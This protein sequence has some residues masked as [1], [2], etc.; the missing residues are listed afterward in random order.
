VLQFSLTAYD[1]T[2]LPGGSIDPLGFERGYLFLADKILPGL[3]NVA[4]RPRY[5]SM[6]CAGAWLADISEHSPV[7]VQYRGRVEAVL[8]FERLWALANVLASDEVGVEALTTSGIRGVTYADRRAKSIY[9]KHASRTDSDFKLL[10]R[11]LTYGAIGIYGYVAQGMQLLDRQTLALTPALGARLAQAF[12]DETILPPQLKRAVRE[13]DNTRVSIGALRD[14]GARAHVSSP[15]GSTESSCL[16]EA[17]YRDPTRSRMLAILEEF[18]ASPGELELDRL[19][20]I[21]EGL[22]G[23]IGSVDLHEAIEAILAYEGV[24]RWLL[25]AFERLLYLGREYTGVTGEHIKEDVV[26]QSVC[27]E[28]PEAIARC[29]SVLN[30]DH[31]APEFRSGLKRVEDVSLFLAVCLEASDSPMML[32]DAILGRH[33]DVQHGKKD[34]GRRKQ[35]WIERQGNEITLTL[36][37]AGRLDEPVDPM[38]VIPHPYRLSS[39]DALIDAAV[40]P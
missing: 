40:V 11:Q 36:T 15:V 6:L 2:D 1:P 23:D 35:P 17:A 32:A 20:R 18:P 33:A 24:Y 16:R 14:W 29:Q 37:A 8:R 22:Q 31:K 28:L 7:R 34:G 21:S 5:F 26:L 4:N 25:L 27:D 9:R 38:Q 3:T 10:S 13:D 19:R 30:E 39:A 12:C